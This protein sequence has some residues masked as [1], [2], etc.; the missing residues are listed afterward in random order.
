MDEEF[1]CGAAG[2]VETGA[3]KASSDGERYKEQISRRRN[4]AKG[5]ERNHL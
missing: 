3:V 1:P 2:R 5:G 4:R